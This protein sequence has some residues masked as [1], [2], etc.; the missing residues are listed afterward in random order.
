MLVEIAKLR[1]ITQNSAHTAP[2]LTICGRACP[3]SG[4]VQ[5]KSVRLWCS[6]HIVF[7]LD[8]HRCNIGRL[9]P[10]CGLCWPI[11]GHLCFTSTR[12]VGP[13]MAD[14]GRVCPELGNVSPGFGLFF[15]RSFKW[16]R[17]V[18]RRRPGCAEV[19]SSIRLYSGSV[20]SFSGLRRLHVIASDRSVRPHR[21]TKRQHPE[22]YH[23]PYTLLVGRVAEYTVVHTAFSSQYRPSHQYESHRICRRYCSWQPRYCPQEKSRQQLNDTLSAHVVVSTPPVSPPRGF[24]RHLD[25]IQSTIVIRSLLGWIQSTFVPMSS[26]A[27]SQSKRCATSSVGR[28]RASQSGSRKLASKRNRQRNAA[29][30]K[31]WQGW[32]TPASNINQLRPLRLIVLPR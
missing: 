15:S 29:A 25:G 32:E 26:L 23:A 22:A 18:A 3:Q 6:G 7:K 19:C 11:L 1:P 30:P 5:P 21:Q 8:K 24:R 28:P 14:I 20:P 13:T 17:Q 16:R 27:A 2:Q 10:N 31:R 12:E 4:L 9:R